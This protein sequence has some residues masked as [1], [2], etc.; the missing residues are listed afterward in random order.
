MRQGGQMHMGYRS[1]GLEGNIRGSRDQSGVTEHPER[2]GGRAGD[3][4][5]SATAG[6]CWCGVSTGD[7]INSGNA[8]PS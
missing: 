7:Y 4:S 1:T 8:H 6:E 5:L 3:G 2:A